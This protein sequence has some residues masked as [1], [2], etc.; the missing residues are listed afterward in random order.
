LTSRTYANISEAFEGA[1]NTPVW[2]VNVNPVNDTAITGVLQNTV[3]IIYWT[4]AAQNP[5]NAILEQ[6]EHAVIALGYNTVDRPSSLDKI[7]AEVL[8]PSGATLT[9]ERN[10]PNLTNLITDL[11]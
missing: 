10:I 4:I 3:A 11:G 8:L 2:Q 6:G 1:V 9:V 7:R 5:P